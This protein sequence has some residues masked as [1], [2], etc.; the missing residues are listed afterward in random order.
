M[1][2]G[3][4]HNPDVKAAGSGNRFMN[5]HRLTAHHATNTCLQLVPKALN[6]LLSHVGAASD[7]RYQVEHWMETVAI[8]AISLLRPFIN[9]QY[10]TEVPDPAR[11]G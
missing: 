3:F 1:A 11:L 9:E 5:A 2:D 8:E 10:G 6:N 4:K 7:I